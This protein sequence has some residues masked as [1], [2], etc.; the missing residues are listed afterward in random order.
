M[1][2]YSDW[3]CRVLVIT[4]SGVS[5]NVGH[6]FCYVQRSPGRYPFLSLKADRKRYHHLHHFLASNGMCAHGFIASL[7]VWEVPDFQ[8]L[9]SLLGIAALGTLGHALVYASLKIGKVSVL[10]PIDYI[11]IIWSTILGYLLFGALPSI[12]LYA[13]SLLIIGA[14]AFISYR[15]MHQPKPLPK[16]ETGYPIL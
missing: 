16:A 1:V 11:R 15:E 4:R 8:Q 5:V 14:T 10:L 2:C 12:R 9:L 6:I 7:F 13:G 3:L